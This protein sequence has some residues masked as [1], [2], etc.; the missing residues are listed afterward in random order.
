MIV[1]VN[2][3]SRLLS[4]GI[5]EKKIKLALAN[6]LYP[7]GCIF[8]SHHKSNMPLEVFIPQFDRTL[9]LFYLS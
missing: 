8:I 7:K 1:G 5:M 4:S 9:Y 6:N 2:G 3:S